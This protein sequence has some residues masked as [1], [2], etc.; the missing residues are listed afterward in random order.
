MSLA[1]HVTSSIFYAH[2]NINSKTFPK[3]KAEIQKCGLTQLCIP[4][5]LSF[6]ISSYNIKLGENLVL[7][8]AHVGK[9]AIDLGNK[10][11]FWDSSLC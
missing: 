6:F 8:H 5:F 9:Y 10:P 2:I 3:L 1:V 11:T 4:L 7:L